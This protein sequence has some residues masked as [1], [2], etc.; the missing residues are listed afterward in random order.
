MRRL[1]HFSAVTFSLRGDSIPTN[2]SRVL[3]T[4]INPDGGNNEQALIC[5]SEKTVSGIS[6]VG[7]WYLHPTR[8]SIDP[9]DRIVSPPPDRG[10]SRNRALDP[11]SHR[12]VRLR[13]SSDTAEEGVLTCNIPG[14]NNTPASV[15]IYYPSESQLHCLY[16]WITTVLQCHGVE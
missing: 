9:G 5:R 7:D 3:I 12:L 11:D 1:L 2:G 13:R 10:W 14:D 4:D 15:V 8:L 6:G 16:K